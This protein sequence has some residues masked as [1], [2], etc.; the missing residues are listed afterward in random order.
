MVRGG[1]APTHISIAN[2]TVIR[3]SSLLMLHAHL[4]ESRKECGSNA[5]DA[6]H[7]LHAREM[8]YICARLKTFRNVVLA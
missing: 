2:S 5:K 4:E 1:T 7:T 3:G 6:L 8:K